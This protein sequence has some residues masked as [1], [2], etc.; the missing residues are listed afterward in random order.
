MYPKM[1]PVSQINIGLDTAAY[2]AEITL[3]LIRLLFAELVSESAYL[4]NMI[5]HD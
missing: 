2:T 3:K 4:K 1:S 5:F